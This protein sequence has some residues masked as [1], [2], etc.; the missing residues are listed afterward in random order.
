MTPE[1]AQSTRTTPTYGGPAT[2]RFTMNGRL[3]RQ[4]SRVL[5]AAFL[6]SAH[7]EPLFKLDERP[8]VRCF[9]VSPG[10]AVVHSLEGTSSSATTVDRD[11]H[12]CSVHRRYS[13][14]VQMTGRAP[15]QVLVIPFRE[16]QAGLRHA[17]LR[18]T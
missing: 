2:D 8:C 7:A 6:D 15:F 14:L 13:C 1:T 9:V 10:L 5:A 3:R 18:R 4:N 17:L 12:G 16:T 11:L